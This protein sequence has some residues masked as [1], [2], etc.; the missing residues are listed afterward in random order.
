MPVRLLCQL[1]WLEGNRRQREG[2]GSSVPHVNDRLRE[3]ADQTGK[4]KIMYRYGP[5]S[6]HPMCHAS[7]HLTSHTLYCSVLQP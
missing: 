1:Q 3:A 6:T 4:V 2:I 5:P 7:S